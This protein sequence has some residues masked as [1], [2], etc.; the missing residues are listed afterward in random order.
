[1]RSSVFRLVTLLVAL[2][3][4]VAAC[5]DDDGG[6]GASSTTTRVSDD[7]VPTTIVRGVGAH[8]CPDGA[9]GGS[10]RVGL[11]YPVTS[12]DP[13][14]A[15]HDGRNGG[16]V[17]SAAYDVLVAWDPETLEF[18][19]Q[20]A[21]SIT[22][23]ADK[24]EWTLELRDGITFPSGAPLDAN[25]VKANLE[26]VLGP[27]SK[28]ST[29]KRELSIVEEIRVVDA[30]TI[31]FRLKKPWGQFPTALTGPAGMMVDPAVVAER[32]ADL[33]F[34]A[35]GA[36]IGP[37]EF[38]TRFAPGEELVMK[39]RENYWGG[40]VCLDEIRFSHSPG[41]AL[42][43]EQFQAGD[44]DVAVLSE[45]MVAAKARNDDVDHLTQEY[46]GYGLLMNVSRGAVP[47]PTADPRV[48]EAIQLAI[49]ENVVNERVWQGLGLVSRELVAPGFP[50]AGGVEAPKYDLE[51]ARELVAEAKADGWD[52]R[53]HFVLS[54]AAE[55]RDLAQVVQ[56]LLGQAGID[57]DV[58]LVSNAQ[59]IEKVI[60][61]VDFDIAQWPIGITPDSPYSGLSS[62]ESD[63]M[64]NFSG[65]ADPA[66]DAAVAAV[67]EAS[68]QEEL[69]AALGETQRAWNATLPFVVVGAQ[70]LTQAHQPRVHGLEQTARGFLLF[71]AVY[72]D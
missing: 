39:R 66:L 52:G 71:D 41:A 69:R 60:I 63:A 56:S 42:T 46:F 58:D 65:I 53:L 48:R 43:Y 20:V 67:R 2:S 37:F 64:P 7:A 14:G 34:D 4:V 44:L 70:Q 18:R 30:D 55:S 25:A 61:N 11:A 45:V 15:A 47:P 10:L 59:L 32:G 54:E 51:R 49:D 3:L 57:V 17:W 19:G 13:V 8:D 26:R 5:G 23:N 62:F 38:T 21:E 29:A 40:E 27:D 68:T 50:L 1:M 24:S 31:V 12:L 22:A 36:G 6:G 16:Q 72:L 9:R 33:V 28:A 35:I